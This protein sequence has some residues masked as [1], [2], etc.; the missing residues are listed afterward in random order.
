MSR[1]PLVERLG[2]GLL[3]AGAAVGVSHL[4]QSTRAGAGYGLALVG[5]IL[6]ANLLKYPAFRFGT[7]YAATR[8]TSLLSAYRHQGRWALAL[9]LLVTAGTLF[10]VQAGVAIVTAGLLGSLLGVADHTLLLTALLLGVCALLLFAGGL[11]SL[12]RA[13]RILVAIFTVGTLAATAAVLPQVDFSTLRLLPPMSLLADP[14]LPFLIALAGW[15][16]SAIDVSVW[17]SL[18][19]VERAHSQP[20]SLRDALLDFHV[21]YGGTTLLALCFA[22]LGAGLL[23]QTQTPIADAPTAFASQLVGLYRETL[24]PTMGWIVGLSAFAVM[25]STTLTVLDGFPR[26]LSHL[27]DEFAILR[28]DSPCDQRRARTYAAAL[29]TQACGALVLLSLLLASLSR[30]I[31]LATTLSFLS[32][33]VLALLNHRAMHSDLIPPTERPA[34]WLSALSLLGIASLT[35]FS[36]YW[37]YFLSQ[38]S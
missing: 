20:V 38:R 23:H 27:A 1:T 30:F 28:G 37:A 29:V 4:V 31:D 3:F 18:W 9:Y 12:I 36:L 5:V 7:Q 16:P 35:S 2:P 14:H 13:T 10:A 11:T 22:L 19:H 15:M 34:R 21:G 6:L 32:A 25:L 26:A 24:G 17:Q 33:P 8:G